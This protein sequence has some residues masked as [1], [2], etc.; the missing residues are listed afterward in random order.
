MHRSLKSSFMFWS[1]TKIHYAFL[2]LPICAFMF[3]QSC[4]GCDHEWFLMKSTNYE[5][6]C[7]VIFYFFFS[8]ETFFYQHI[9]RFVLKHFYYE[10]NGTSIPEFD[11][12]LTWL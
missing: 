2:T 8:C 1:L 3:H 6:S 11:G 5:A 9:L 4:P 12:I 7:C 10:M